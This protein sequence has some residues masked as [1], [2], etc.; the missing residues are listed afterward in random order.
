MRRLVVCRC[1]G[2]GSGCSEVP[3][4][5]AE[6]TAE[7]SARPSSGGPP[8]SSANSGPTAVGP[9]GPARPG[10]MT[11]LCTLALLNAGVEPDDDSIRPRPGLSAQPEQHLRD[12]LR[13]VAQI[14]VFCRASRKRRQLRI[15]ENVRVARGEADHRGEH[16]GAWS[17]PVQGD[18]DNSNTQFA[19]L[20][21]HE[22]ER[23]GVAGQSPDLG[24]GQG[25]TGRTARTPTAPGATSPATPAPAA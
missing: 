13:R 23:I 16:K 11:A 21:L 18:G 12:H 3:A 25:S 4:A 10:G 15:A 6:I 7:P 8:F 9:T 22:A 5:R 14:M 1:A 17:Y 24:V 20:A 19:M 2:G